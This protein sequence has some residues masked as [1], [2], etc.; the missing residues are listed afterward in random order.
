MIPGWLMSS[1]DPSFANMHPSG[2]H[3]SKWN[4]HYR[5]DLRVGKQQSRRYP[6][7][8]RGQRL[9]LAEEQTLRSINP[10]RLSNPSGVP[11]LSCG[12]SCIAAAPSTFSATFAIISTSPASTSLPSEAK[13]LSKLPERSLSGACNGWTRE[14]GRR[15]GVPLLTFR[16]L[17]AFVATSSFS[18]L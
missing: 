6:Q 1:H 17:A 4:C 10:R 15:H 9:A 18:G 16:E 12:C 5:P 11:I 13:R 2:R 7:K 3:Q 14:T 8:G